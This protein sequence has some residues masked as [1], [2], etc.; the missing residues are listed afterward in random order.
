MSVAEVKG[1]CPGAHRPM[2][3]AD[4][5][6]VRVRPRK[7]RLTVDQAL[8]LCDLSLRY[9]RGELELT[10]RANL[11]IRAVRE[12]AHEPL[13]ADLDAI[14][15]L[16]GDPALETRRNILVA[17]DWQAGDLNDRLA[18]ALHHILPHLPE[19]PAKIGYA[20]DAGDRPILQDAP[21]D[22][23]FEQSD[24]GLILRADGAP[25][26]RPV[27]EATAMTALTEMATWFTAHQTPERRRLARVLE[28]QTLPPDWTTA[29]P[30]PPAAR[31]APGQTPHGPLIGAPFGHLG[32]RDLA[33][34]IMDS[35]AE[36]LRLTPWRMVLLEGG[37]MPLQ[38]PFITAPGSPLLASDACTGAPGCPQATVA[39]R[40][41]ARKLAEHTDRSVHISGCAKSCARQSPAALTLVG[42]DG[43]FDLIENG[44]ASDPPTRRGLTPTQIL[45]D[46]PE[47]P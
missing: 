17:P 29:A 25:R 15:L 45:T 26:G 28:T 34:A 30:H 22:F 19:M 31:P 20:L 3:A 27:T 44:R 5:L 21:A 2:L 7:G 16:D 40:A 42:R 9:G 6:V 8:G 39:T 47:R 35:D 18:E 38:T 4:G 33:N 11:Q 13:L 37:E 23:R 46:I 12:R 10:R 14:G 43:R 24:A 36:A 1:W 41:L 32:A